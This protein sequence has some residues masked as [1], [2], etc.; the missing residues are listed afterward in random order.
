MK[1]VKIK[2]SSLHDI[3]LWESKTLR[4]QEEAK[5]QIVKTLTS[6]GF[7][8]LTGEWHMD[9]HQNLSIIFDYLIPNGHIEFKISVSGWGQNTQ[10][11]E[12]SA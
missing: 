1:R 10:T 7:R 2:P 5:K 6:G 12:V 9:E 3:A 8:A 11:N 4:Y